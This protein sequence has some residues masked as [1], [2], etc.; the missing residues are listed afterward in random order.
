MTLNFH[1]SYLSLLS[2]KTTGLDHCAWLL[3]SLCKMLL[4]KDRKLLG[5]PLISNQSPQASP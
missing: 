1:S 3:S 5:F 2:R 4:V